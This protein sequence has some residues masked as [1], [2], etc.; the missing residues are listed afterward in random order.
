MSQQGRRTR[1]SVLSRLDQARLEM[2]QMKVRSIRIFAPTYQ[3]HRFVASRLVCRSPFRVF[4]DNSFQRDGDKNGRR[5]LVRREILSFARS[6]CPQD[7]KVCS[8]CH[9]RSRYKR[10]GT[11]C[12][13]HGLIRRAEGPRNAATIYAKNR[14]QV[15]AKS[16]LCA[17][18][19]PLLGYLPD[20]GSITITARRREVR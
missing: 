10:L 15:P 9:A 19:M 5:G 1:T 6:L 12:A 16:Q 7:R 20:N 11:V 4:T 8:C 2:H 18:Y 13:G 3:S 14:R 17:S